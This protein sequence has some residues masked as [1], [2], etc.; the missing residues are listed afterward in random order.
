METWRVKGMSCRY[1]ERR[2]LDRSHQK[3]LHKGVQ[4]AGPLE[5]GQDKERTEDTILRNGDN[6]IR[7]ARRL[8]Q[9]FDLFLTSVATWSNQQVGKFKDRNLQK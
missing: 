1:S 7:A 9:A 2:N 3:R 4:L 6:V 5:D 8:K